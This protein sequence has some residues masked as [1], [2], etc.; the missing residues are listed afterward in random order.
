MS[1][2]VVPSLTRVTIDSHVCTWSAQRPAADTAWLP[3]HVGLD[4]KRV[5][6]ALLLL[7]PIVMLFALDLYENGFAMGG[8]CDF[9]FGKRLWSVQ[10]SAIRGYFLEKLP[11]S[12]KVDSVVCTGF[13]DSTVVATF[14]V[15]HGD[16]KRLVSKLEATFLS[17]QNH[18]IVGDS[19]KRRKMIGPPSR[20]TYIYYLPGLQLFDVR[21]VSISIP[22]NVNEASTVVFDGG[23]N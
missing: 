9:G 8:A 2:T 21:T 7:S 6:T 10:E 3:D 20:S 23:N 11:S 12:I 22:N 13:T 18:P 15:S 16:A 19:Q 4:M 1:T 17:R 5:A 14:H